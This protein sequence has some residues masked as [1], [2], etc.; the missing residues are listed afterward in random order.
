MEFCVARQTNVD[1][2]LHYLDDFLFGGKKGTNKCAYIMS[3]FHGKMALLGVPM[4][5]DKTNA[6]K[7]K[8]VFWGLEIYSEEMLVRIPATKISD[9]TQN[10]RQI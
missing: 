6:K 8:S 1:R 2:L 4:S 5:S 3:A 7:Q 9:I 10:L